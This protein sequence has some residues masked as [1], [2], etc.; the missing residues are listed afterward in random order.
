MQVFLGI[1]LADAR[2][3]VATAMRRSGHP[4]RACDLLIRACHAITPAGNA[5]PDALATYGNLLNVAA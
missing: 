1:T 5:S 3:A 4:D 2:R